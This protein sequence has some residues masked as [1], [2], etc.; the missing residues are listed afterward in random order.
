MRE[1]LSVEQS[2]LPRVF[3][4]APSVLESDLVIMLEPTD[5][6]IHGTG[7][8]D[9]INADLSSVVLA[10]SGVGEFNQITLGKKLTGKRAGVR[11]SGPSRAS[12][13]TKRGVGARSHRPARAESV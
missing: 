9:V 1:E 2:A 13:V 6:A 5:N 3:A 7:G 4:E 11:A 10:V 8:E 12:R